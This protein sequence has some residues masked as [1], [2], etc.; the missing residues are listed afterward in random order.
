MRRFYVQQ[1]WFL[2]PGIG[3]LLV[4]VYV[5]L[6]YLHKQMFWTATEALIVDRTSKEVGGEVSLYLH[7][8]FT[9]SNGSLHRVIDGTENSYIEGRDP[10][11]AWIYYDPA[12]P[13]DFALVNHFRYMLIIFIPFALFLVY[14]GWPHKD[15][16]D[17]DL[18]HKPSQQRTP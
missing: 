5:P 7:L 1:L 17:V 3:L 10:D 18:T 14:L 4:T 13:G 2:I 11:Y 6:S 15:T 9:D 12:N 8:E 16:E